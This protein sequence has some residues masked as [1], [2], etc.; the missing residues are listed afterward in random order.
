MFNMLI[1]IAF[2]VLIFASDTFALWKIEYDALLEIQEVNASSFEN[3][4]IQYQISSYDNDGWTDLDIN[5]SEIKDGNKYLGTGV[6]VFGRIE[7]KKINF[8]IK[9]TKDFLVSAPIELTIY[10]KRVTFLKLYKTDNTNSAPSSLLKK[11]NFL[12]YYE[13]Q[14]PVN[15]YEKDKSNKTRLIEPLPMHI[16]QPGSIMHHNWEIL[17]YV[18]SGATVYFKIGKNDI[19][20]MK[21]NVT[22]SFEYNWIVPDFFAYGEYW[23][24]IVIE[25]DTVINYGSEQR[26]FYIGEAFDSDGDGYYDTE[27]IA[28]NSDPYNAKDVPLLITSDACCTNG[29]EGQQYYLI[30][31]VN[32]NKRKAYWRA[33]TE[34]PPGLDLTEQ[35]VLYGLPKENGIFVFNIEVTNEDN[36]KDQVRFFLN[37]EKADP[38]VIKM[39]N[40]YYY[41]P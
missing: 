24:Q 37:I 20:L 17:N 36:K 32:N 4:N 16:I 41:Q 23:W 28:R 19:E 15:S 1:T 22:D 30:L 9:N 35:G 12:P 33:L 8:R 11:L 25:Y 40:G 14:L 5:N 7:G 18:C 34:L 39:G 13:I 27:E 31:K 6:D 10:P 26:I 2:I 3:Y 29:Y 38:S 21:I